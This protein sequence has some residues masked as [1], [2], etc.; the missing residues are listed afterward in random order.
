M[1]TQPWMPDP[2]TWYGTA[3]L[4]PT[5]PVEAG[6]YGAWTITY[7]V[8]RYGVDN[9]GRLKV[10]MR[11]ASDWGTP[12]TTDPRADNYLTVSTTGEARLE[13]RYD[14]KG[15]LRPWFSTIV[16]RVYDGSLSEG[17]RVFIRIG[18]R[19]GGSRGS[20]AQTFPER[21]FEFRVLVESFETGLF[22]EVPGSTRLD[23]VG[24]PPHRLVVVTPSLVEPGEAFWVVVKAEDRW[25]NLCDRYDGTAELSGAEGLPDRHRFIPGDGGIL[26]WEEAVLRT[27]GTHRITATDRAG[28]LSGRSNPVQC[29][30]T[31]GLHR[32][33]WGDIH[34]QT[35]ET[36]GTGTA[37]TYF[38]FARDIAAVDFCAHAANDFQVTQAHWTDL[39]QQ[40]KTYH[41]PGRFVTFLGYEWSGSTPAGGDHNV[42]FLRDDQVIH[43]SSH[44]QVADRSDAVNDRYPLSALLQEFRG[45]PDVMVIPHVGGRHANLD[46]FAPSLEPVIEICSTHGR[47]E[48]LLE[49]ALRRGHRVGVIGGSDDH[50]GRPGASRGTA[51][52]LCV[53]GGLA[54]VY[55]RALTREGVWEALRSRRCY[56]TTGER[57]ILWVEADGHPM[58]T[59]FL[60]TSPPEFRVEVVGTAPLELVEIRRGLEA[61]YSHPLAEVAADG[62]WRVKVAWGGARLKGRGRQTR[63]DGRL[64]IERGRLL[65]VEEFG[66][67]IPLQGVVRRDAQS[68]EWRS[69]TAGDIDGLDLEVDGGAE[70]I[71][72]F[73]SG[74]ASFRLALGELKNGPVR[75]NAG[76]VDQHVRVWRAPATP[77]PTEA[78]FTFTD[79]AVRP[80]THAY[81]VRVLQADGEMAWS[82]P[83]YVTIPPSS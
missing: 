35:G 34:G 53:Q 56:A 66:F 10:A 42:Y 57:I 49:E 44:W 20:R 62:P 52:S 39:C 78:A 27:P 71:L 58:G 36:V 64:V 32:L 63:W 14:P 37:E 31:A 75:V 79:R 83:I 28:N 77:T 18:D 69:S 80:G 48:W 12:Q 55:A 16:I 3:R 72:S 4:E 65:T 70:T 22:V 76:G 13:A 68:V 46:Y 1:E 47:F 19:T 5:S 54:A 25:G 23:V 38:R 33:F 2:E 82:S 50:T 45:N 26:R 21:G 81:F 17:D 30:Q 61:V 43:R 73:E 51:G 15:H 11:L 24:G 41:Q 7:R 40:V 8:G 59:E 67:D 6:S 9:G 60:A 74:P 29:R